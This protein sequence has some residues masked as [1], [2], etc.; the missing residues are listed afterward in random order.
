MIVPVRCT[1]KFRKF[2]KINPHAYM[3]MAIKQSKNRSETSK[4]ENRIN[5]RLQ[6]KNRIGFKINQGI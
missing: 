4:P 5:N 6:T 1:E 2:T 3:M